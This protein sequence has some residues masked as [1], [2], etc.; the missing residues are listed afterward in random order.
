MWEDPDDLDPTALEVQLQV[1]QKNLPH[2]INC[3]VSLMRS[4]PMAEL[5]THWV[6][7]HHFETHHNLFTGNNQL[8]RQKGRTCLQKDWT[9]CTLHT[10]GRPPLQ[11]TNKCRTKEKGI[12]LKRRSQR[13]RKPNHPH[14]RK[15]EKHS[16]ILQPNPNEKD[17][18]KK[19]QTEVMKMRKRNQNKSIKKQWSSI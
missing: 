6:E 17:I 3:Y 16:W 15:E 2:S 19:H 4:G 7:S 18:R 10:E 5:L 9:T 12:W 13:E 11:R 1:D 14:W 8:E